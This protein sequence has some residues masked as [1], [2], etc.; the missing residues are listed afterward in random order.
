MT[1]PSIPP[2]AERRRRRRLAGLVIGAVALGAFAIAPAGSAKTSKVGATS[3]AKAA[4]AGAAR[5]MF[6]SISVTEIATG[7]IFDLA[8]LA[9]T[10][11][12][13]T[14]LWFWAPN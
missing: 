11:G 3:G 8:K 2:T 14:L 9:D 5:P 6:P 10:G 12:R 1:T 13:P 7:Q 4:K